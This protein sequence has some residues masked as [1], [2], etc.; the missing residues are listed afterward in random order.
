MP[1]LHRALLFCVLVGGMALLMFAGYMYFRARLPA[2]DVSMSRFP[3]L[4]QEAWR[5]RNQSAEEARLRAIE[6]S[7]E[8][9][10]N[11]NRYCLMDDY[12]SAL[13]EFRKAA[14]LDAGN[15]DACLEIGR[16]A[17]LLKQMPVARDGW[18]RALELDLLAATAHAGLFEMLREGDEKE[19][20]RAFRH[21]LTL[22]VLSPHRPAPRE[23]ILLNPEIAREIE[24]VA[25][26][27]ADATLAALDS[28]AL[29]AR[30]WEALP[31]ENQRTA[32][33]CF[34]QILA[35]FRVAE[36]QPGS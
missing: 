9:V 8:C 10:A 11:G 23:F 15:L 7:R 12:P 18:Q 4:V 3:D 29:L 6:A 30:A 24:L 25:N 22:H 26:D 32:D 31:K 13:R 33:A 5:K 14:E 17:G 2:T 20:R 19:R 28:R 36:A 34:G 35:R 21:A 1:P 16:V 27:A